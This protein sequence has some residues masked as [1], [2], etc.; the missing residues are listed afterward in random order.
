MDKAVAIGF[1][2]NHYETVI[3]IIIMDS[4]ILQ[5]PMSKSLKNSA[6]EVAN[7]YGFSSLQD[8]LRVILTKLSKRELVISIHEPTTL[9]SKKNDLRYTTMSKDFTATKSTKNFSSA[10]DL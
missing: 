1:L 6:Q 9:L 3:F 7:E 10:D 2:T 8:L 5:V 4:T